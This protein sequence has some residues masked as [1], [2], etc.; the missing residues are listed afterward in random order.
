MVNS[1]IYAR[2]KRGKRRKNLGDPG[3]GT[4]GRQM[5]RMSEEA[6]ASVLVRSY[7]GRA[8]LQRRADAAL[9]EAPSRVM[10]DAAL[11]EKVA[12]PSLITRC[13]YGN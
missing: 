8:A 13:A 9:A 4:G 2:V 10:S 1:A 5:V 6:E 11:P 12:A 3:S 7:R